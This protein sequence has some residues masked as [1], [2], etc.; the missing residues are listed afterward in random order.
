MSKLARQKGLKFIA[1][2]TTGLFGFDFLIYFDNLLIGLRLTTLE[3]ISWSLIQ[4]VKT[5]YL[6]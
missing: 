2:E 1:A 3:M 6:E 4:L 5:L